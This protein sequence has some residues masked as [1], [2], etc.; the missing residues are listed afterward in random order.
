MLL[1]AILKKSVLA[2][3][4]ILKVPA[5]LCIVCNETEAQKTR[6]VAILPLAGK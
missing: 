4:A 3:G 1:P 5:R 6:K 2:T